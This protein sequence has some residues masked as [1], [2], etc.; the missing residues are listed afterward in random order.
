MP[1]SLENFLSVEMWRMIAH[2]SQIFVKISGILLH[3]NKVK[4]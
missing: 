4:I 2:L 1:L 3:P